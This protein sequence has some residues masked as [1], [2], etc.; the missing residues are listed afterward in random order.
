MFRFTRSIIKWGVIGG[1][2]IV[3]LTAIVGSTRVK[4][5]FMSVRDHIRSNVDELVDTKVALQHEVDKLQKEYPKRIAEIRVQQRSVDRD[6][7]QCERQLHE[8]EEV[9]AVALG[10]LEVL[11]DRLDRTDADA[12]G[13]GAPAI[14]FRARRLSRGAAL[15]RAAEAADVAKSYEDR[16]ID[17]RNERKLLFD[18]KARLAGE[19]AELTQEYAKF[20]A[21]VATIGRDIDSLERKEKLVALAERRRGEREDI[22][23][24]RATSLTVLKDRIASRK[25]ELEEKLKGMNSRAGSNEYEARARLRLTARTAD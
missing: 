24:D 23:A 17:L 10:D 14:E 22:F 18:E 8:S 1:L 9:V 20:Q 25:I 2:G 11:R 12:D 5:A 21:E 4:T 3:G 6:L 19:R 16:A 13:L 7:A 15:D